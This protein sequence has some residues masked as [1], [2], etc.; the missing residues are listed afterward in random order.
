ML[1][2][3]EPGGVSIGGHLVGEPMKKLRSMRASAQSFPNAPGA[4]GQFMPGNCAVP[5]ATFWMQ[6]TS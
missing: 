4:F 1:I 3:G 2:K 6:F 5:I